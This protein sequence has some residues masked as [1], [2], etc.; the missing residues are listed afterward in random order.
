MRTAPVITNLANILALCLDKTLPPLPWLT[1]GSA[2]QRAVNF[3][4]RWIFWL[5]AKSGSMVS[6]LISLTW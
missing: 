1:D 4:A 3:Q 5:R 6:A 2:A